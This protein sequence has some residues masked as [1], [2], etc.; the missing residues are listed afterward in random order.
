M[1]T[2]SG[3]VPSRAEANA[4]R[5]ATQHGFT[6]IEILIV[7]AIVAVLAA[8]ALPNYQQYIQ[9]G[10]RAQARAGLLQAAQWMERVATAN[11]VYPETTP[12][13]TPLPASLRS[14]AGPRYI[15]SLKTSTQAAYTLMA[16][17]QGAQT[18]DHCATLTLGH[19]GVRG[20]MLGSTAGSA[21]VVAECW[22]R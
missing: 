5:P 20:V 14:S 1:I 7:V 12:T 22:S 13:S 11:G 3:K 6:L 15:L 18:S 4:L 16:T 2:V 21:D 19:T 17:P 9:R 8:I 10:H